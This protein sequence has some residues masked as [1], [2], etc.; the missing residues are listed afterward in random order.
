M[1]T[2]LL[3]FLV[4]AWAST[5]LP[6]CL[7][8][9]DEGLAVTRWLGASEADSLGRAL[10]ERNA[11]A[12]SIAPALASAVGASQDPELVRLAFQLTAVDGLA[13]VVELATMPGYLRTRGDD[14]LGP[15]RDGYE[16]VAVYPLRFVRRATIGEGSFC[17]EYQVPSHFHESLRSGRLKL[18]MSTQWMTLPGGGRELV[19]V[20]DY[21]LGDDDTVE[22]I[23]RQRVCGKATALSVV[24]RGDSLQVFMVHD[25]E[26]IYVRK[27]G[28]HRLGALA[29]WRSVGSQRLRK[30]RV[31][32]CAYFPRLKLSLPS[33]LPDLGLEDLREFGYPQ[34]IMPRTWAMYPDQHLPAWLA[35]TPTGAVAGWKS[36][37]PRPAI[38]ES[39]LPDL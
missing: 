13:L 37:G 16:N 26:G 17:L 3:I 23:F 19:L 10:V 22:M 20:R 9:E 33:F 4:N 7:L 32:A 25:L 31:G 15:L 29:M 35:L 18:R 30:P 5:A 28:T 6:P 14:P 34:P 24:D 36:L 39:L 12:L 1:G 21:P 27:F 11:E 2:C 38:L 8:C